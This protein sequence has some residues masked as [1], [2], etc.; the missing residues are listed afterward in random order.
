VEDDF[1]VLTL[2]RPLCL[3]ASLAAVCAANA[4]SFGGWSARRL[5]D[6]AA[7]LHLLPPEER[8]ARQTELV[9]RYS[10]DQAWPLTEGQGDGAPKPRVK[11]VDS[12]T[13]I[14]VESGELVVPMHFYPQMMAMALLVGHD[15][16]VD[17][18]E[19]IPVAAPL[20]FR[21][22]AER[23]LLGIHPSAGGLFDPE[24]FL[25][26]AGLA[27]AAL[28]GPSAPD[29]QRSQ[30]MAVLCS[31]I[32]VVAHEAT[33]VRRK[34]QP[35]VGGT[36]PIAE[37]LQA[38]DGA[39]RALLKYVENLRSEGEANSEVERTSCLA[40]PAVFFE[41][42]RRR[43]PGEVAKKEYQQRTEA[44]LAALGSERAAVEDLLVLETESTGLGKLEVRWTGTPELVVIDGVPVEA[45]DIGRLVL[46]AGRHRIVAS[47]LG[48]LVVSEVRIHAGRTTRVATDLEPFA[49]AAAGDVASLLEKRQWTD[50]L[51]ATSNPSLR[52]KSPVL[53]V[54][55]WNALRALGLGAWVDQRDL[56][57]ATGRDARNAK[58]WQAS[59]K[60]LSA[61]DL[62]LVSATD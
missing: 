2:L 18:G 37:E 14:H 59:G 58:R 42:N 5:A 51:L 60:P 52:P 9:A 32:F 44:V 47:G 55:H 33:H 23:K 6:A 8:W 41:L 11:V 7:S 57:H 34:H 3:V 12:S 19:E 16:A 24:Q 53:A 30:G 4:Q 38:D 31:S 17:A 20:L 10:V 50:V 26:A 29:C 21:P 25:H 27:F 43:A 62:D 13:P 15:V 48:G 49:S 61:W 35:R 45:A 40:S 39:I 22:F 28:C 54:P 56:V 46:S 1:R 36:Y